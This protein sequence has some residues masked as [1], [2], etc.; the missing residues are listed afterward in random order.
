MYL[1]HVFV[2]NAFVLESEHI[3]SKRK[4]LDFKLDLAHN[5]R[6][7]ITMKAKP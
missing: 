6:W 2:C 7:F 3:G 5:N 4:T 1:Y